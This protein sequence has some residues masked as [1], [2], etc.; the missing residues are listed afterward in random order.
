MNGFIT[1]WMYLPQEDVFV[2]VCTNSDFNNPEDMT[3]KFAALAIGKPYEYEA[4]NVD[5]NTLKQYAGVY[6]NEK[7]LLRTIRVT[8]KQLYS[9]AGRGPGALL[10][11]IKKDEFYFNDDVMVSVEFVRNAK[12]QIEKM[13][14]RSRTAIDTWKKTN[15]PVPSADGIKVDEKILATYVGEYEIN[16]D[17]KV[18]VIREGQSLFVQAPG[19]E[20]LQMFAESATKFFLKVNDAE[21]EFV[22]DAEGKVSKVILQQSGRKMEAKKVN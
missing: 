9:H 11:G 16:P 3:A 20:K 13:M 21:F 22:K 15:K 17:V 7:G 6:E 19:Q 12:G 5:E 14:T 1:F 10:K 2:I 4:I 8:D 18:K